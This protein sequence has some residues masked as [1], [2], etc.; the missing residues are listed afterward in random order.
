[1]TP[2]ASG[3]AAE[4]VTKDGLD[5]RAESFRSTC[6]GGFDGSFDILW[7]RSTSVVFLWGRCGG[8]PR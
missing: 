1:M 6:S 5:R 4:E 7:D 2:E 3:D 8:V